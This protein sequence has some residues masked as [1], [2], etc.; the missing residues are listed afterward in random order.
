MPDF[1][2]LLLASP[3]GAIDLLEINDMVR[4]TDLSTCVDIKSVSGTLANR[5]APAFPI[6]IAE[7]QR[8]TREIVRIALDRFNNRETIDIRAWWQDS[9]GNWRPGRSGLTLAIKHL[10]DLADGLANALQRARVL[11]LVEPLNGTKTKDRTAAERQRRYRQRR[12]GGVT[13]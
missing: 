8:N 11:G 4:Q 6:I 3:T 7:W 2:L 13:V 12:N 5:P 9:E 10:P 1:L